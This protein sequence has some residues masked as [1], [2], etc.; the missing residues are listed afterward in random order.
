MMLNDDGILLHVELDLPNRHPEKLPLVI[1]IHG[2]TGDMEEPHILGIRD[3]ILETG[4]G[5]LRAELYGHGRSGGEFQK[6]NLFKWLNNLLTVADYAMKLPFVSELYLCGHSQ[7]GLLV[8]LAGFMLRDR[9][10]GLIPLSPAW[11]IPEQA[12]AG[13]FLGIQFDPEQ[14]PDQISLGPGEWLEGNYIRVAMTIDAEAAIR[15]YPGPVLLIHGTDD[16]TV[17]SHWS[18]KAAGLYANCRLA[19]I[20]GDTHCYDRHLDQVIRVIQEWLE[21]RLPES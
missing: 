14:I 20:P 6:H 7:G 13:C 17:Q 8:M 5:V 12:R 18:E 16:L 2:F 15:Q 21:E 3:A 10:S 4:C 11:M 1:L 19:L 9:V